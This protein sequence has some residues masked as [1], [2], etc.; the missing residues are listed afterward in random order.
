MSDK[1]SGGNKDVDPSDLPGP[2]PAPGDI[3][4]ELR[5]AMM[6]PAPMVSVLGELMEMFDAEVLRLHSRGWQTPALMWVVA[7]LQEERVR[8]RPRALTG[9]AVARRLGWPTDT[10]EVLLHT[11]LRFGLAK[12]IGGRWRAGWDPVAVI[13]SYTRLSGGPA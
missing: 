13:G 8:R 7:V 9:R 11:A 10:V 12:Q 1:F 4:D 6:A 3:I 5:A 2:V